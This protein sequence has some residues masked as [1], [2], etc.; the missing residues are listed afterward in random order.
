MFW[1]P[2]LA[3]LLHVTLVPGVGLYVLH[4]YL[5]L[6]SDFSIAQATIAH[7]KS[8]P[9]AAFSM[10]IK[11]NTEHINQPLYISSIS[12]SRSSSNPSGGKSPT[13]T[14]SGFTKTPVLFGHVKYRFPLT[15]PSFFPVGSSSSTPT[16]IGSG[17][18]GSTVSISTPGCGITGTG[19]TKRTVPRRTCGGVEGRII[20]RLETDISRHGKRKQR[21]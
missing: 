1:L 4:L 8:D 20:A 11:P 10:E 19:P 17:V 21:N 13:S 9:V 18:E 16:Q 6:L 5:Y 14:F 3:I 15:L 7:G 12:P 2:N